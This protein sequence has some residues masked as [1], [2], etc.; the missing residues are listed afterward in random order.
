MTH[1]KRIDVLH[2]IGLLSPGGAERNLYYLTRYMA[3]S[4][5]AYGIACLFRRGELADEIES[6]GIPIF[7]LGYR[8]RKLIPTVLRLAWLLRKRKVR[9][10]HTH[11]FESGFVGRLAAWLARTPVVI[12]HEH[13]KT[14]WKKWYHRAFERL[15]IHGTDLR[16][17]VSS[18]IV[19]L[20]MKLEGTPPSKLRLV[21]NAVDPEIFRRSEA[22]RT[23]KRNELG[24]E[25]FLIVGSVGRLVEAK[26]FDLLLEVARQVSHK[27]HD[28]HFL[29]VG[30]GP[31]R[32]ELEN[33]AFALGLEGIVT[34]LGSRHDVPELMAAMDIYLIT[35]RREG[36]PL[37][38]IEAM[39]AAK[40]IVA[41]AVGGIPDTLRPDQDGILVPPHD[42]ASLADAVIRLSDDPPLRQKLGASARAK[43]VERYS[44]P[45]ILKELETI[46]EELL[47]SK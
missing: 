10:I 31:L 20:R 19:N 37:S 9:V 18:D 3:K 21:Y 23:S 22:S 25:D 17:A 26:G 4:R 45:S 2:V 41:T 24:L 30:D 46:Y 7:E 5:F 40:P 15:A 35:S 1:L 42:V 28:I 47:G 32:A 29:I 6:H 27:R 38:L 13:G 11:L 39:M 33:L 34:F 43:A 8:Q 36:L 44:P 14:L 16:I 12:T